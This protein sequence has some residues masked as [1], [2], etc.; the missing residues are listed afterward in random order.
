VGYRIKSLR[1]VKEDA[2]ECHA[3]REGRVN[4][5]EELE[6]KVASVERRSKASLR[7]G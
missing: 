4:V 2:G 3:T 6:K 1:Y 7:R 5:S